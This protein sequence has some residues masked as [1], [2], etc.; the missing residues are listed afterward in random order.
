[1]TVEE[2]LAKA[3]KEVM[4]EQVSNSST[5]TTDTQ[6]STAPEVEVQQADT[7]TL[8]STSKSGC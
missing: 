8:Q 5:D 4:Q 3:A 6:P 1:M 2:L 7:A